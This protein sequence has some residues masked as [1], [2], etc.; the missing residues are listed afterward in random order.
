MWS[1][2]LQNSTCMCICSTVH[3]VHS[4][5]HVEHR[6]SVI[7]VAQPYLTRAEE[8]WLVL[9]FCCPASGLHHQPQPGVQGG[10]G[11]RVCDLPAAGTEGTRQQ[12]QGPKQAVCRCVRNTKAL[13][14]SVLVSSESEG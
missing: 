4:S 11:P 3:V 13:T 8:H 9:L 10:A 14:G 6:S 7:C 12:E 5:Q 2:L 1:S